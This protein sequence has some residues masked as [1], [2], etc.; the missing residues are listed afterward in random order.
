MRYDDGKKSWSRIGTLA[1]VSAKS[2]PPNTNVDKRAAAGKHN[3]FP[4]LV[5]V[6]DIDFRSHDWYAATSIGLLV[7]ADHG[8]TWKLKQAGPLASLPLQSVRVSPNGQR[9]RVASQRGLLYSDDAAKSW[10][11]H[12]LPL[13]SGGAMALIDPPG[14]ENTLVAIAHTGLYIS[15][16]SGKTWQAAASGFPSA[17][18][19]DFAATSSIFAASMRTGG[20]YLSSDSGTTLSRAGGNLADGSFIAVAPSEIPGTIFAA[21]STEGLYKVEWLGAH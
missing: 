15:R 2:H 3:N 20:L 5:L 8:L 18:V 14:D 6:S 9:I 17:P 21:S 10:E 4:L 13:D 12:D 11:W 19:Q 7:S 16:D 1:D